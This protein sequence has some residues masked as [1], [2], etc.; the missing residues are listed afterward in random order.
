MCNI[1]FSSRDLSSV[2]VTYDHTHNKHNYLTHL[3]SEFP[4]PTSYFVP[5]LYL[6]HSMNLSQFDVVYYVNYLRI[7]LLRFPRYN[8]S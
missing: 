5:D 7:R 8:W 3:L 1:I 6:H 4:R 2:L